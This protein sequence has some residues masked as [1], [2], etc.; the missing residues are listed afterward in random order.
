MAAG[1]P[2]LNSGSDPT[3]ALQALYS[4]PAA[5][6]HAVTSGYNGFS[7]EAGYDMLTGLGSPVANLLIPALVSYG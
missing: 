6:F 1:N 3:Q 2:T 7:A 5:D 4:L